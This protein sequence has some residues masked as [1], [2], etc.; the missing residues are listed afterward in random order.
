MPKCKNC[1]KYY[2]T[3]EKS[4]RGLG[5]HA[6]G[7]DVGKEMVGKDN[8]IWVVVLHK[9]HIKKW[10]QKPLSSS[11][12]YIFCG[13]EFHDLKYEKKYEE[14]EWGILQ[15]KTDPYR[16]NSWIPYGIANKDGHVQIIKNALGFE[17]TPIQIDT[18]RKI[19]LSL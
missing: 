18:M 8:K 5:Y 1:E 13:Y 10:T 15:N 9:N 6:S 12:V 7:E 14:H 3:K 4:P 2:T 19:L 17:E 11:S 16:R